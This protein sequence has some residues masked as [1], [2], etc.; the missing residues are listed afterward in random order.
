MW[1]ETKILLIDDNA[2]RRHETAIVLN[3]L[4]EEHL[5]CG[6]HDWREAVAGLDSSRDVLSVL[7]G[8]MES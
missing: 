2:A 8:E 3:F 1:R 5:A 6:S 7:L 4:G